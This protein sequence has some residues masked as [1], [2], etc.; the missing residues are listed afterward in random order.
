MGRYNADDFEGEFDLPLPMRGSLEGGQHVR[1]VAK[2][3]GTWSVLKRSSNGIWPNA[4]VDEDTGRFVLATYPVNH[5]VNEVNIVHDDDIGMFFVVD[6]AQ[7][8]AYNWIDKEKYNHHELD[9][10]RITE[11]FSKD[12]IPHLISRDPETE[13]GRAIALWRP[14]AQTL[15]DMLSRTPFDHPKTLLEAA[16][17][18]GRKLQIDRGNIPQRLTSNQNSQGRGNPEKAKELH[19]KFFES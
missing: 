3:T 6:T 12:D 18:V 13:Y 5:D 11:D 10:F 2:L 4:I 15:E 16:N 1:A 8:D 9:E 14:S 7:Y 17:E 19:R